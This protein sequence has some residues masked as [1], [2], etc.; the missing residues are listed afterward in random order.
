MDSLYNKIKTDQLIARKN[1]NQTETKVLTMLLSEAD[2]QQIS[3]ALTQQEHN[4]LMTDI[5]LKYDK[6]LTKNIE[7]FSNNKDYVFELE[8]EHDILS[9]Y[10]PE[11][12]S[13]DQIISIINSRE[14]WDGFKNLMKFLSQ[15]YK[16]LFD[17]NLVKEI[18]N[19]K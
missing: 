7:T 1:K 8:Q 13:R 5:V 3:K 10:L 19:E 2:R 11:K 18:W 4:K 6:Q 9:K 15:D 14:N 17:P 12:L 16:G